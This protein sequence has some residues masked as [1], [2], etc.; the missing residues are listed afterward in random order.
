MR[1]SLLAAGLGL[2]SA[3]QDSGVKKVIQLLGELKGKVEAENAQG[4]KDAEEKADW[5][6]ASITGLEKDVQY[7]AEKVEDS[8]GRMEKGNG[9]VA[10]AAGQIAELGPAIQ[11]L[12]KNAKE[13]T[14][15]RKAEH[16]DF[17][18]TESELVEADGMLQK[19]YAVLKR[20]LS[21]TQVGDNG[22]SQK[23]MTEVVAALGAIVDAAVFDEDSQKKVQSFLE[24]EDGL[25]LHQ[26]QAKSS[27]Y[28]SKSGGILDVIQKMQD[29][30][31]EE[32]Q[33]L[34]ENEMNA[35][36]KH[37]MLVQDLKNQQANKEE[38]LGLAQENEGKAQAAAK[39]AEADLATA[40]DAHKA[41][42]DELRSTKSGCKKYAKNWETENE[43]DKQEAA[44]IQQAIDILS[45]KFGGN[46]FLQ[47]STKSRS[48][49][50]F[51]ARTDAANL[52]RRMSRQF[53][54]FGFMQV[55]TSA[56]D[57]PFVKVRGLIKD[58]ITKLEDEAEKEASKEA[59]CKADKAKGAKQ[60]K[61]KQ[62]DFEKLS[63]RAD[64]AAA[65]SAKLKQEE[66]ELAAQ[67]KEEAA[68]VASATKLRN[69]ER[70]SNNATIKDAK[71]SI[72]AL[73]G[74]IK[75]LEDFYGSDTSFLQVKTRKEGDT[76]GVILEILATA[77]EDFEKMLL[78]TQQNESA[79]SAD[80]DKLVQKDAV[81]KAKKTAEKE[82]K[83]KE[84]AAIKVQSSQITEDIGEAEKALDAAG[85]FVKTVNEQ[86]ANKAMSYEERQKRRADE[87]KGLQEALKI[88][89]AEEG[90]DFLQVSGFLQRK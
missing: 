9:D 88:L 2:A 86:C 11:D 30:N 73:S 75:V 81:S 60:L 70:K 41:D 47:T 27:N 43:E 16:N 89:S 59:K 23:Y 25:S 63:S 85:A 46:S 78:T 62:A 5:C 57:D 32:L 71:E 58:M 77:Q 39:Q 36:H 20:A 87:I 80:Y 67:L 22:A 7:G 74:A 12:D 14:K 28:E 51:R 49:H 38:Q 1:V 21:F 13:A 35:R 3:S 6:I 24:S 79:A 45:G 56:Q 29:K 52:L 8:Q 18:K 82:G 10:A 55:A 37:E 15:L 54:S 72:E 61:I 42:K 84:Q 64:S 31:S 66:K 90:D 69:K 26:P 40:S 19:A 44:V 76:A 34:R 53:N 4:A 17:A 50:E 33:K 68:S 83:V 65:K 48:E